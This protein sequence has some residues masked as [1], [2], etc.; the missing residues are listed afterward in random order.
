MEQRLRGLEGQIRTVLGLAVAEPDQSSAVEVPA[1][2]AESS[3][4]AEPSPAADAASGP[5]DATGTH[6]H[7]EPQERLDLP[8]FLR[9]VPD[10]ADHARTPTAPEPSAA[11]SRDFEGDVPADAADRPP[12]AVPTH[13]PQVAATVAALAAA[14]SAARETAADADVAPDA[15]SGAT[16]R[17]PTASRAPISQRAQPSGTPASGRPK[18]APGPQVPGAY[19]AASLRSLASSSP[20]A[21]G[22]SAD[23]SS[24]GARPSP[25]SLVFSGVASYRQASVLELAIADLLPDGEV[26]IVEFEGGNLELSV[27]VPNLRE[28]AEQIVAA[29][30]ASLALDAVTDGRATFRC[31]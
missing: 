16:N 30:P 28:L 10:L 20:P 29:A 23:S 1:P 5:A 19:R 15:V 3:D 24:P 22:A 31:L 7:G 11:T 8:P 13:S 14:L 25:V 4:R 27:R 12:P 9:L 6:E 17:P 21:S 2:D 18:P 26:D